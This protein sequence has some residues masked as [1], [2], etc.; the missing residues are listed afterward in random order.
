MSDA[1]RRPPCCDA[2]STAM[3][4]EAPVAHRL[5]PS[6][7]ST[8]MSTGVEPG[9]RP[10]FSPMKSMGASSR[11]PSPITMV[12]SMSTLSISLRMDSTATWSEYLRSPCPMV[13]AAAI[14]AR[15]TTRTNSR[16]RS[17]RCMAGWLPCLPS[18]G[19]QLDAPGLVV[20][21]AQ[22]VVGLHQLVDLAGPLVDD[23]RLGVAEEAAGG[24]LVGIAVAAVDLD[25]VGGGALALDG[26]EPLGQRGLAVVA[27]ALVLQPAGPQPKQARRVVVR[28]H[29]GD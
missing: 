26:G 3:A 13:R 14:A 9:P 23:R 4:L 28:H 5:V 11:S 21:V 24:V 10:T 17:S 1:L 12:P 6:S 19:R 27:A 8:A 7:G 2:A 29:L 22:G 18:V 16:G 25:A 15:S 20:P